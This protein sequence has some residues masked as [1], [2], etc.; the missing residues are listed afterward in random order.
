MGLLTVTATGQ[1][2]SLASCDICPVP[3][4][5]PRVPGPLRPI[6]KEQAGAS[7]VSNFCGLGSFLLN[8]G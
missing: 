5:C 1:H 3:S 4:V 8:L 7:G 2:A 6:M